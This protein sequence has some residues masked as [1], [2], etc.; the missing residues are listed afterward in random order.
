M[1]EVHAIDETAGPAPSVSRSVAVATDI[2]QALLLI[3]VVGW[4]IDLPRR[5][6]GL[7]FYT[8]QLLAVC[9]GLALALSFINARYQRPVIGWIGAALALIICGY[10]AYR[11]EDL[12]LS[13]AM[14]PTEGVIGSAIIVLLVLEATRRS[15]G[16]V[17]VAIILVISAYVFI[18]PHMPGDFATRT[19]SPER[20]LVYYGL[21][22]NAII[23]SILS[24][25][26]LI[27]VPFTLMGQVLGRT[28]G[29][30]Y[31]ADLAMSGMG[32]FRGGAAKIAVVGSG[33]FGLISGAAV[34]NVM[35][36]GI[37]TIPLMARSGFTR[38]RAAAI[39]AVGSTGG[40]LMPPVMGAAA[41]IMAEFLQVSYGAVCI[42][43]AIPALL[44]Y[45]ALFFHVDLEAAKHKIGAAQV[46]D[47]PRFSEVVKSGWHF[48]IPLIFL[49]ATL[50]WPEVFQIPIERAAVYATAI[51]IVLCLVFGYRGKRVTPRE[52]LRAILDTGKAALDIILIGAAAGMVV[53][54]LN[55]SGISFGLTLQ[56]ISLAGEN[57]FVLLL[58]TAIISIILGM[59]MPTVSVYVLTASLLAPSII[60]LGV[61]PMAAHMF[62]MYFGMLSMI[63]PPVA[64]AAYAAANIARVP[65]WNAG[66]TAVVVGWSTFFIPF[67]FVTEP[68]ML[69]N[70]TWPAIIWNLARNLLG[71]FI[72]TAGIVG[73]AVAPLSTPLRLG[74]VAAAV[75]ILIPPHVFAGAQWLDWAGLT[76]AV[77]LLA[78]NWM[79]SRAQKQTAPQVAAP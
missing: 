7:S 34:S 36:V 39:E 9:L 75:A 20:L 24:V 78:F 46:E 79:Q 37:V 19:V 10:I 71:I 60:K 57:L 50:A 13:I 11:Y 69:M 49:I 5:L 51:M 61:S 2:L 25:A 1:S 76:G 63:T 41:F 35:A 29:A 16:G 70:D 12:T 30:A 8:E 17:L 67:L 23:G 54:A 64:I 18:G 48:P 53:G 40:Q 4:V 33:L 68:S 77:A 38:T 22:T 62:V 32:S 27:V 47:M 55:I 15:A 66:W 3:C 31:F 42:A 58:L 65:G 43:A 26:V 6:F 56:L 44:Y 14:L 74:F 72:G 73:F 59:G 21:D 52:M 45:A 28:G